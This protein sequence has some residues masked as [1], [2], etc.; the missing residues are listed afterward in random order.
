MI[1]NL[2]YPILAKSYAGNPNGVWLQSSS[3]ADF[4][5]ADH[6]PGDMPLA[7]QF[8]REKGGGRITYR[9][10]TENDILYKKVCPLKKID[11]QWNDFAYEFDTHPSAAYKQIL[12]KR[13]AELRTKTEFEQLQINMRTGLE[14]NTEEGLSIFP[15]K[16]FDRSKHEQQQALNDYIIIGNDIY[17]KSEEPVF[18][19]Y[20]ISSGWKTSLSKDGA[21]GMSIKNAQYHF[22]LDQYDEMIDWKADLCAKTNTSGTV[23]IFESSGVYVAKRNGLYIDIDQLCKRATLNFANYAAGLEAPTDLRQNKEVNYEGIN[24][25]PFPLLKS[26]FKICEYREIPISERNEDQTNDIILELQKYSNIISEMKLPL[27][28]V[29]LSILNSHVEKWESRPITITPQVNLTNKM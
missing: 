17:I 8:K 24:S 5:I 29:K 6:T 23:D 12:K 15:Q 25:V 10:D 27:D 3:W 14:E 22:S 19:V 20:K 2:Q 13:A 26:Y 16:S 7:F 1:I 4:E 18:T 21:D 9:H 28:G 11:A